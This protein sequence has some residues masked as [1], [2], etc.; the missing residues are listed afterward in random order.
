MREGLYHIEM[1]ELSIVAAELRLM[2][3][4][5]LAEIAETYSMTMK[6]AMIVVADRM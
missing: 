5:D 3:T 6:R 1:K 2:T 4:V